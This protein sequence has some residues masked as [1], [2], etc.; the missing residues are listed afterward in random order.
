[1][2]T[3]PGIARTMVGSAAWDVRDVADARRRRPAVDLSGWA[4][5][6]G[7]D[8]HGSANTS[9]WSAVL[10]GEPELQFNVVR[11]TSAG[12]RDVCLWHCRHP[13]PVAWQA[14]GPALGGEDHHDLRLQVPLP[15]AGDAAP[16]HV[17]L[18]CTTAGAAVPEAALT[19]AFGVT[20]RRGVPEGGPGPA[21]ALVDGAL[22]ELLR[23]G[24]RHAVFELSYRFGVLL[25]RRNGYADEAGMDELLTMLDAGARALCV[26]ASPPAPLPFATELPPS[27]DRPPAPLLAEVRRLARHHRLRSEDPRHY[28]RAFPTVPVPGTAW[29]VLRGRLPGA[30][31]LARLALHTEAPLPDGVGR[32][33]LLLPSGSAAATPPGGRQL[34]GAPVPLRYAVVDGL[35]AAWVTRSGA[36]GLG[37]VVTLLSEGTALARRLSVLPD[38]WPDPERTPLPLPR[39]RPGT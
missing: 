19:P 24:A 29:A 3:G 2:V 6:R 9:G 23:R 14:G 18:P 28:H 8:F 12:G 22:G 37:D 33:A 7:L 5:G 39:G 30:G 34:L 10:P 11:G 16:G 4:A 32:T 1:M 17:G 26:A 27:R 21:A 25:L 31:V 35:F 15:R 20:L 36:G 13:V 38:R